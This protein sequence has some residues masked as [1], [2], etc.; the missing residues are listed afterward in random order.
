MVGPGAIEALADRFVV[1]SLLGSGAMGSVHRVL[2]RAR[3]HEVALKV[4]ESGGGRELYRFKREF[5]LL[6]DI[7]HHNVV[8]LHE[9]YTAGDA[10]MF[11]MELVEGVPFHR[12]VRPVSDEPEEDELTRPRNLSFP[13]RVTVPGVLDETRLRAALGQ[14]ADGLHALHATGKL[15]RDIKPSNVLVTREGRV[16]ILD[17]GLV[18]ELGGLKLDRTH[19]NAAVGTPMYMSPEQAADEPLTEASDWYAVGVMLYEV[20]AG[21]RP[22]HGP[23]M[24]V[25]FAKRHEV[26][27]P[28]G[29][30]APG[31]PV[32]LEALCLRLMARDPRDRPDGAAVLAVLGR[33]A[34]ASTERL[35]AASRPP[36]FV[37][38]SVE[39]SALRQ[40]F[41][42]S[43]A[44]VEVVSLVGPSGIGKSALVRAFLDEIGAAGAAVTLTGTCYERETVPFK[45]LDQVIDGLTAH[46]VTQPDLER[47]AL[48][49]G[50]ASAL[51]RL[52]PV[53]RRVPGLSTA[54]GKLVLLDPVDVRRRGLNQLREMLAAVASAQPMVIVVDDLQ[55]G[56]LDG[57]HALADLITGTGAPHALVVVVHRPVENDVIDA[58]YARLARGAREVRRVALGELPAGE[59]HELWSALGGAGEAP[60]GSAGGVP[61]LLAE[62]AVAHG[63]DGGAASFEEVVRARVARLGARARA[64]IQA[65][66]LAARPMRANLLASALGDHTEELA[67]AALESERLVRCHGSPELLVEPYHDRIR[68]AVIADMSDDERRPRPAPRT[69]RSAVRCGASSASATCSRWSDERAAG[70]GRVF[71]GRRPPQPG[72]RDHRA[73]ERQRQRG[74]R[75]RLAGGP[76]G[77]GACH[78]RHRAAGRRQ[79]D[80]GVCP[81]RPAARARP[82]GGGG[83]G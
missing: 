32:D 19:E 18:A 62:L 9:L 21:V 23:P 69:A 44:G 46:L 57:V 30:F 1:K 2:D 22:F 34:S 28:P 54:P 13:D 26:P 70:F 56:D 52:F 83:G 17:F 82:H 15:H 8:R 59:A 4:L 38:R 48:L 67:L 6:A 42:V 53:M 20:L 65:S 29:H 36:P 45:V 75:A 50:D 33:Q 55:W 43:R 64:L 5:R 58:W 41:T 11:T 78:R 81:D 73:R 72:A 31:V 39:L 80:T 79:V 24:K 35:R 61:L 47:V 76:C 14:L 51:L 3:G 71:V 25:L 63:A 60:L 66:A 49:P 7:V 37:G 77:P 40:A 16:V 74:R 68:Q 12:W 27:L 10:W